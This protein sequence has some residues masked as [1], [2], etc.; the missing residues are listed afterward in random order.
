MIRR[1]LFLLS[2]SL[3]SGC[4]RKGKDWS[5][6]VVSKAENPRNGQANFTSARAEVIDDNCGLFHP[7]C[8]SVRLL[9][10]TGLANEHGGRVFT[11]MGRSES[12][13]VQWKDASTLKIRCN[14]CDSRD[15]KTQL[16]TI[17]F[18]HIEYEL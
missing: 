9:D 13:T 4:S 1:A 14:H 12:V 16:A 2:I 17:N 7:S 11:Y 3:L 8:I 5:A 10:E 18:T 15:V 6:H